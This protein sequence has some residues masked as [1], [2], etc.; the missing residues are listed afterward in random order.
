MATDGVSRIVWSEG[1]SNT[2]VS[3]PLISDDMIFVIT[4]NGYLHANDLKTGQERWK[5]PVKVEG[6][7]NPLIIHD[8][9]F[10]GSD[11]SN[12]YAHD[13][14]TGTPLWKYETGGPIYGE[15]P[16]FYSGQI[17]FGSSD[18]F[19]YALNYENGSLLWKLDGNP[20]KLDDDDHRNGFLS[21]AMSD[22]ILVV[23][24]EDVAQDFLGGIDLG[25]RVF[26]WKNHKVYEVDDF[27]IWEEDLFVNSY[28]QGGEFTR[29]NL[30]TGEIKET[31]KIGGIDDYY[32]GIPFVSDDMI[33]IEPEFG[34]IIAINKE[35]G[36]IIWRD[37]DC[38]PSI[39]TEDFLICT[40]WEKLIFIDRESFEQKSSFH[41]PLEKGD[42]MKVQVFGN[43]VYIT[44]TSKYL[45]AL[46]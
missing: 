15:P 36:K 5:I 12:F 42:I 16:I 40:Y 35:T 33:Y 25:E 44:T 29:L 26:V 11:D 18:G 39:V 7:K 41:L 37:S 23:Y 21:M 34:G 3:Q 9:I 28:N 31:Y 45:I 2:I 13:L 20:E 32:Y 24:Y 8:F 27:S 19:I 10:Y 30:Y 17:I 1:F 4:R 6:N 46:E 43:R 22:G 14:K 38:C